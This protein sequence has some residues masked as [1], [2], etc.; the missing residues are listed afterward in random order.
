MSVC[1]DPVHPCFLWLIAGT[2]MPH[3]NGINRRLFSVSSMLLSTTATLGYSAGSTA[4][5]TFEPTWGTLLP[6]G[7][8]FCSPKV[9]VFGITL[10]SV[11]VAWK[12]YFYGRCTERPCCSVLQADDS[13]KPTL[14]PSEQHVRPYHQSLHHLSYHST[15]NGSTSHVLRLQSSPLCQ[16]QPI[17]FAF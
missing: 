5:T 3:A 12:T 6:L 13:Q 10:C 11:L 4:P 2:Y 9:R 14:L 16:H 8:V 15:T 17:I 7:H 1:P